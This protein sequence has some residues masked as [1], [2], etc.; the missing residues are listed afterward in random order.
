MQSEYPFGMKSIAF[1]GRSS[2]LIKA[3]LK[4]IEKYG[5]MAYSLA[6]DPTKSCYPTY[7]DGIKTKKVF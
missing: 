6:L 1:D 4:D 5:D 7:K 3:E 2:M